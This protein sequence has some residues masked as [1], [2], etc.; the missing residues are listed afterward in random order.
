[1]EQPQKSPDK[2]FPKRERHCWQAR[3]CATQTKL[4]SLRR[5]LSQAGPAARPGSESINHPSLSTP[6]SDP[7]AN[8][9]YVLWVHHVRKLC[10]DASLVPGTDS[11]RV[12]KQKSTGKERDKEGSQ[13]RKLMLSKHSSSES[14]PGYRENRG[15]KGN[16]RVC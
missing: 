1:M 6:C 3:D 4:L 13:R 9:P 7:R 12:T 15:Q 2:V 10:P 8:S 16:T 14:L 5:S 11:K